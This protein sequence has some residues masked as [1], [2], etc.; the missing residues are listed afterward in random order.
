MQKT[1]RKVSG[2]IYGFYCD[3]FEAVLTAFIRYLEWLEG[4]VRDQ[5]VSEVAKTN[6][7]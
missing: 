4:A 5:L 1:K 7:C 3:N 6:L 2:S